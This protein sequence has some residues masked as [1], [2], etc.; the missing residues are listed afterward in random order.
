MKRLKKSEKKRKKRKKRKNESGK[1]IFHLLSEK[2][3]ELK[4]T[5]EIID[6]FYYSHLHFKK[7]DY[8]C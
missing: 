8:Y 3:E 4:N 2:E 6:T 7:N 5:R 1:E